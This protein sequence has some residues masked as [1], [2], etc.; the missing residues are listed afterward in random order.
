MDNH[1]QERMSSDH[2]YGKTVPPT[3]VS[4]GSNSQNQAGK[5]YGE[6]EI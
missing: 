4:Q 2:P 3:T 6:D 5:G 1:N